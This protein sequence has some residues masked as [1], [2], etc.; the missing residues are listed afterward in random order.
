MTTQPQLV[1]YTTVTHLVR[2]RSIVGT[3][4][5]FVRCKPADLF[6]VEEIWV[7]KHEKVQVSDLERT[8]LDGLKQPD[9]CGG[10]IEVA[11]G[12]WIKREALDV[13]KLVDYALKLNIGAVIRRLGFLMEL[14]QLPATAE[15]ERLR[16][17]LTATYHRFDPGLTAEGKFFSRWKLQLNISEAELLNAV[18]T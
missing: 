16:D 11:K 2:P 12:F 10:M 8:I 6:G 15:I 4:F 17:K 5:R 1:V 18:R 3:E 14:Y 9:Y 7:D 13:P